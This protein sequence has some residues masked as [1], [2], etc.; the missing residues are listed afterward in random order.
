MLA[1]LLRKRSDNPIRV[2]EIAA[3]LTLTIWRHWRAAMSEKENPQIAFPEEL[4]ERIAATIGVTVEEKRQWLAYH[5]HDLANDVDSYRTHDLL[6]KPAK[7]VG[8]L[9]QIE[10]GCSRL[11]QRFTSPPTDIAKTVPGLTK[12]P[13]L[14]SI[15]WEL[16]A[17]LDEKNPSRAVED[18]SAETLLEEKLQAIRDLRGAATG[19]RKAAE[20]EVIHRRG[21]DR[22]NDDWAL[23]EAIGQLSVLFAEVTGR[24]PGTSFNF[25]TN[26]AAG[27]FIRFL[28]LC[29]EPLGWKVTPDAIRARVRRLKEPEE[30]DEADDR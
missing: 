9:G 28:G 24:P 6:K 19:A 11:L 30:T 4:I 29:L 17:I 21:G 3:G 25:K 15:L 14:A 7:L 18:G 16:A 12:N 13:V 26:K 10:Q 20:P 8:T 5:L 22:R 2:S 1:C 27:P 23:N